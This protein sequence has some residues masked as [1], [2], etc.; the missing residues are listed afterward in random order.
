[1]NVLAWIVA[2]GMGWGWSWGMAAEAPKPNPTTQSEEGRYRS[3][4]LFA[5]VVE[6]VRDDYLELE[7]TDY[8]KMTY[9]ALRGLLSS[10]DPDSQFLDPDHYKMIRTET[11]GQFGG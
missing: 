9:A 8:D 11:E 4:L 7:K 10:L 3:A 2:V 5:S 6:M 1:M